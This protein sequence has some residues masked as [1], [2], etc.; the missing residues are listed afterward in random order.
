MTNICMTKA[1]KK[2]ICQKSA[3]SLNFGRTNSYF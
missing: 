2:C 3:G 1:L